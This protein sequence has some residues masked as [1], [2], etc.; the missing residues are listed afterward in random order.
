MDYKSM[1]AE[2]RRACNLLLTILQTKVQKL[3]ISVVGQHNQ[4]A[5]RFAYGQVQEL[6][7]TEHLALM[8]SYPI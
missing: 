4:L 2:Q 8:N 6:I 7:E 3:D 5:L 1:T